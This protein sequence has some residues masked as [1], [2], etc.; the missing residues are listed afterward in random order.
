MSDKIRWGILGTGRIARQ[1]AEGLKVLPDAKLVAVGSRTA[2]PANAFGKEFGVSHRHASYEALVNDPEVDVIYVATPHS[3]H[4]ENSLLALAAGKAVLCEKPFAINAREAGEVITFAR[5]KKLFL[6]EAMWT[7]C[8]PLMVKLRE[9]LKAQAIGEVRMVTADFGFRAEY[10]EEERLFNPAFGGGALLDVGVY[11]VSLASMIFGTPTRITSLA[12]LGKT[13]VDEEAAIIL[14]HGQGQLAVLHTAI[15]VETPQE[16]VI[17][18]TAGRIRI[19]REWWRPRAMTLSLDGRRD[20]T[21][22]FPLKGNGYQF[23][24]AEVMNCLRA[25]KLE[26]SVMPLDETLSIMKT[27]DAI[28]AQWGLKYPME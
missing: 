16:A 7:R 11:P 1:F 15:R 9:L 27:L 4:K 2:D 23:E 17:M 13:G 25:G 21:T 20:E 3:C 10:H 6:M 19:H 26:S 14:A 22:K 8:F 28:R 5:Q 18:G 24:A 12:H